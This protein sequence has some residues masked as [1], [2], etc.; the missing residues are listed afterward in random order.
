MGLTLE[1]VN[2][3]TLTAASAAFLPDHE[4]AALVSR[5]STWLNGGSA[6]QAQ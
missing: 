1:E 5:F 4:R 6:S 3:I 2:Q